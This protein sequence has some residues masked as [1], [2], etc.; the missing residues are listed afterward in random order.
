[1]RSQHLLAAVCLLQHEEHLFFCLVDGDS[2]SILE[3]YTSLQPLAQ[4]LATAKT[5]CRLGH[6]F[7]GRARACLGWDPFGEV[8][9]ARKRA[10]NMIATSD[11]GTGLAQ[12]WDSSSETG[13]VTI[14]KEAQEPAVPYLFWDKTCP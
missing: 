9:A 13:D 7:C 11:V 10:G 14:P 12:R 6:Y 2:W 4:S 3:P 5:S 1:M 8:I